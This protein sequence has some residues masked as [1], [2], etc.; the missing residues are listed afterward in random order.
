MVNNK[1]A[2]STSV[3]DRRQSGTDIVS[4]GTFVL[5]IS[6]FTT[7]FIAVFGLASKISY[8]WEFHSKWV[9]LGFVLVCFFASI[10]GGAIAESNFSPLTSTVGGIICAGALGVMV[11]PFF[12]RYSS[13]QIVQAFVVTTCVVICTGLIGFV[14]QK[15]LQSWLYPLLAGLLGLIVVTFIL[16]NSSLLNYIGIGLFCLMMVYD[17]NKAKFLDRTYNNAI[18][19]AVNV[20]LNFANILIRVLA[21]SSSKK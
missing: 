7:I 4:E 21:L 6:M 20:F 18:G 19:I 5:L 13:G 8:N 16:P 14:V 1:M 10:G 12:A 17:I 2:T 15:N 9:F 3:F 11:G